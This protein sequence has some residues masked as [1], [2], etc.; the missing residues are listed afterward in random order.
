MDN[1]IAPLAAPPPTYQPYPF[2]VSSRRGITFPTSPHRLDQDSKARNASG[3]TILFRHPTA[4]DNGG[5]PL[6]SPPFLCILSAQPHPCAAVIFPFLCR[7]PAVC[8]REVSSSASEVLQLW[9][10]LLAALAVISLPFLQGGPRC[11]VLWDLWDQPQEW[12]TS[13]VSQPCPQTI[14][15]SGPWEFA[16]SFP[17]HFLCQN[18]HF[19]LSLVTLQ[20]MMW[21]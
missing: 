13:E 3:P 15:S 5:L 11:K 21:H 19:F 17:K 7:L 9:P 18:Q 10:L 16:S 8:A 14:P 1:H 2:A 12:P 6:P 4:N 20:H